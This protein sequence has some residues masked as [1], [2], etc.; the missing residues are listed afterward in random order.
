LRASYGQDYQQR[1]RVP[2]G[3]PAGVAEVFG[4]AAAFD[5]DLILDGQSD[6]LHVTAEQVEPAE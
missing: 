5:L 2:A 3:T 4:D 1:R 6:T